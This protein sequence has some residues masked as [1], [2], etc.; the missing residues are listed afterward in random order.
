MP[1]DSYLKKSF[2]FN[3]CKK[4]EDLNNGKFSLPSCEE[5]DKAPI[6]KSKQERNRESA[7]KC[8]QRKK[9]YIAN[10]ELKLKTVQEELAVCKYELEIIKGEM[11]CKLEKRFTDL[12]RDILSQ[13]KAVINHNLTIPKVD[14]LLNR[15][16]VLFFYNN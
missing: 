10:L 4:G 2:L 12:R 5:F 14:E 7:K 3:E 1:N 11:T 13:A 6:K 8:R 9:E 16:I 15:Y